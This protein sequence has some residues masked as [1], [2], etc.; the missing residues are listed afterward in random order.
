VFPIRDSAGR[1]AAFTGRALADDPAKYLNSPETELYHKSEILFG[2]DR[3]KD[4]ARTRGFTLLV[5]GQ[6]DVI[7]AHQAGFENAVALSGTALSEK[8]LE[9]MKRCSENVMLVLDADA[10]GLSATAKSAALALRQGLKVKAA[11][12]PSG[13][14][15]ADLL[16]ED[17]ASGGK[18]FL[19][20]IAGAKPIVDFFLEVLTEQ[21]HN[22]HKLVAAAEIVVLPLIAAMQSP[23]E[24]EHF[25]QGT[26]RTLGL[27]S[28]SVRESLRK[29]PQVPPEG[30]IAPMQ[31]TIKRSAR[32]LR[33]DLLLA[34][35][36][37]YSGT[38]LA[39]RVKSEYSRI[40][41]VRLSPPYTLPESV[42][43]QAEQMLGEEPKEDAADEL[44]RAFE[45]TVV[46]EEHQEAVVLLRKA[47]ARGDVSAIA[48]AQTACAKVA[49][50]LAA[51]SR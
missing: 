46:R 50:R 28:E 32:E 48:D 31:K 18:E 41:G 43:F 44:L 42:L 25:A 2:M 35:V 51:F 23:M 22:P 8:H 5:E 9:L 4:A 1:V 7:L 39:E 34:I 33:S 29:I 26:A 16:S 45:E 49:V 13:K 15:P 6:I 38:S 37:A 10:A 21:E 19:K 47:E 3:A 40:T 30:A 24:R 12:L 20:R 36:Q 27:S 11:K 14:D 17:P